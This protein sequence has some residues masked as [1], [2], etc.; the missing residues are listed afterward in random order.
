MSGEHHHRS[1]FSSKNRPFKGKSKGAREKANR[2]KV[3]LNSALA[4]GRTSAS[5]AS[6]RAS[7]A[8][9]AGAHRIPIKHSMELAS[10]DARIHRAKQLRTAAREALFQAKRVGNRQGPP[11]CIAL[12]ALS[13]RVDIMQL[14]NHINAYADKTQEGV[15]EEMKKVE[16]S[17]NPLLQTIAVKSVAPHVRTASTAACV[18]D[19]ISLSRVPLMTHL[20]FTIFRGCSLPLHEAVTLM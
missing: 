4:S 13:A 16:K 6:T 11:K 1:L 18:R 10:K 3:D 19:S 17:T 5:I 12:V 20:L 2:G 14:A 15:A 7:G 8:G 9:T